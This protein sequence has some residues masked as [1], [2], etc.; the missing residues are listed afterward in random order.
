MLHAVGLLLVLQQPSPA[1]QAP[2]PIARAAVQPAEVAIQVG[3]TVR[4]TGSAQ[5]SAGRPFPNT[6]GARHLG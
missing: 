4:L 3:D 6:T 1:P 5:D 2:S